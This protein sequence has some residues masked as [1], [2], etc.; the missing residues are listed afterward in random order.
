MIWNKIIYKDCMNEEDGLPTLEDKSIDLCLTDPPYNINASITKGLRYKQSRNVIIYSDNIE[1]YMEW[2]FK[3]FTELK[4]LCKMIIF[5]CGRTNIRKWLLFDDFYIIIWLNLNCS[6]RG[7][8]SKFMKYEPLLCYGDFK[9]NK[10]L[11]D[12][13]NIYSKSGFLL[14]KKEREIIHSHPKPRKLY[15]S[16]ISQLKPKSVIDPFMGS[17]TTAEVCTKLGIPYIGYEINEVY[18]QDIDKRLRNCKKEPQQTKLK[19]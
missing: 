9:K 1:N 19:I 16:I 4:R 8:I 14:S 18:K 2:C 15:H 12:V 17:G 13:F 7:Y 5:T 3:W 10:L 11:S 6:S